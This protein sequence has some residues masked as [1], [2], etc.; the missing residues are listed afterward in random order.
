MAKKKQGL[1]EME[2]KRLYRDGI[3]EVEDLGRELHRMGE[4]VP[5]PVLCGWVREAVCRQ[6]RTL[7]GRPVRAHAMF[8]VGSAINIVGTLDY[9]PGS[10]QFEVGDGALRFALADVSWV[11]MNSR[12][13]EAL[14]LIKLASPRDFGQSR[15]ADEYVT[16]G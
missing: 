8:G 12:E 2:A 11:A 1:V 4:K 14:P 3:V 5:R 13:Q 7:A 15:V 16:Q 10:R 9:K 6:L